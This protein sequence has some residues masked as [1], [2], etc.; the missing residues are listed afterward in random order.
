MN[1]ILTLSTSALARRHALSALLVWLDF[2][3][4]RIHKEKVH[5]CVRIRNKSRLGM[6]LSLDTVT[7]TTFERGLKLRKML[8]RA[9]CS[10]VNKRLDCGVGRRIY[11]IRRLVIHFLGKDC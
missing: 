4:W 6:M 7:E 10:R 2:T 8:N 3:D 5:D 11:L 9:D 1:F